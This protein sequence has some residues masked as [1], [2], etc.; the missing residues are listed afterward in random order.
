MRN[1]KT[2]ENQ[3]SYKYCEMTKRLHVYENRLF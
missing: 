2:Q 1:K 3:K